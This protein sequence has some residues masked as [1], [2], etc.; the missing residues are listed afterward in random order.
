MRVISRQAASESAANRAVE[1]GSAPYTTSGPRK[2]ATTPVP[3][4]S[5][6]AR[7][8]GSFISAATSA[9][10]R[11]ASA[12]TT[13]PTTTDID[14]RGA[15]PVG[16]AGQRD[17]DGG[18]KRG[19]RQP[20]FERGPRHDQRRRLVAPQRLADEAVALDEVAGDAGVVG[21]VLGYGE[22]RRLAAA[23]A[24]TTSAMAKT[25][26]GAEPGLAPARDEGAA[27]RSAAAHASGRS[28][29]GRSAAHGV[30]PA[31]RPSPAAVQIG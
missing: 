14:L 24:R 9:P 19:Q 29:A 8:T 5:V 31:H 1:S 10:R 16:R 23:I 21:R 17:R 15:E 3:T 4:P 27:R 11:H 25:A 30:A 22:T 13:E 6:R 28:A 7:P 2:Q 18:E 26:P 12:A 20:H